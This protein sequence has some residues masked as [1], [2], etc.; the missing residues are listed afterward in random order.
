[1]AGIDKGELKKLV[2]S[3]CVNRD[4]C[5]SECGAFRRLIHESFIVE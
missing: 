4:F 1:M 2:C 5:K 3:E